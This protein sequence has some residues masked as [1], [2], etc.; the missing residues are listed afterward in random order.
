ML[1]LNEASKVTGLNTP[2]LLLLALSG[3]IPFTKDADTRRV[4]F[5]RVALSA[6]RSRGTRHAEK[7]LSNF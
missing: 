5:E 1:T 7:H 2:E 4:S 3:Q 6:W